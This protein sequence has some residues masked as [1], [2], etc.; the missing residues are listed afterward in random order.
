MGSLCLLYFEPDKTLGPSGPNGS[1]VSTVLPF[2]N[3]LLGSRHFGVLGEWCEKSKG[4]S[5]VS[6]QHFIDLQ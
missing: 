5:V 4:A 6:L 2:L 1:T 3:V